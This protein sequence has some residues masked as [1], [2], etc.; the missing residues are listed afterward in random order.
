MT[1]RLLHTDFELSYIVEVLPASA[2]AMVN[3]SAAAAELSHPSHASNA[4]LA[5]LV[6][7]AHLLPA[8]PQCAAVLSAGQSIDLRFAEAP[9]I[10]V[11]DSART[12]AVS[13][14]VQLMVATADA[15]VAD[16]VLASDSS[17]VQ[18]LDCVATALSG[19]TADNAA[20]LKAVS[21]SAAEYLAVR[22]GA[23][24][25]LSV[26]A[27]SGSQPAWT[28]STC[29]KGDLRGITIAGIISAQVEGMRVLDTEFPGFSDDFG[30][31][32]VSYAGTSD[33]P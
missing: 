7:Q 28:V 31:R 23:Q 22:G 32:F 6:Q 24:P 14:S 2:G 5:A 20:A 15:S 4:M 11:N 27:L 12:V 30:V 18:F 16:A 8:G 17:A 21:T 9:A 3:M 29:D 19:L 26:V 13:G 25:L 10:E 33:S 1:T